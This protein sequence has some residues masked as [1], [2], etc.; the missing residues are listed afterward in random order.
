MNF[1]PNIPTPIQEAE[2][3]I[4]KQLRK[5]LHLNCENNMRC[6]DTACNGHY[7]P[8]C[9]ECEY[10]GWIKITDRLPENNEWIYLGNAK[11][12]MV[13]WGVFMDGKFVNPDQKYYEI[14][15]VTHWMPTPKPPREGK[16]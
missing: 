11:H 15:L 9:D 8:I 13:T 12:Q 10:T 16:E 7:K 6:L 3:R 4:A 5:A 1:N 14:P 2:F